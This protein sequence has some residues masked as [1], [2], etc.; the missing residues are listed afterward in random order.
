MLSGP[1]LALKR[2]V[3]ETTHVMGPP[4]NVKPL[5]LDQSKEFWQEITDLGW[6]KEDTP[7]LTIKVTV[8]LSQVAKL[9]HSVISDKHSKCRRGFTAE[10]GSGVIRLFWW[11][12]NE[13]TLELKEA[14]QIVIGIRK[15]AQQ[16][17]GYA[18]IET[19]P[20]FLKRE[21]DVWGNTPP[22]IN[23][24]KRIKS[25][26]DPDGLLNPGRFLGDI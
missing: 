3:R 25:Q 6:S 8:L 18:I 16:L 7:Y 1:P 19:C 11:K 14:R 17:G 12:D 23:L 2:K 5:T 24:M 22:T 20:I 15:L 10:V 4:V 9:L 21:L 13:Q 26:Y